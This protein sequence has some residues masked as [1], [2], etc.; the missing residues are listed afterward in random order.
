[1]IPTDG[2]QPAEMAYRLWDPLMTRDLVRLDVDL[3]D[4]TWLPRD[5]VEEIL[6]PHMQAAFAGLLAAAQYQDVRLVAEVSGAR[7]DD[8][9]P[10]PPGGED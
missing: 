5:Q 9:T 4:G 10:T 1:M 3:G 6:R 7:E 2:Y 8:I